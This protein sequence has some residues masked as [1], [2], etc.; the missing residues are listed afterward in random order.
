MKYLITLIALFIGANAMGQNLKLLTKS[1]QDVLDYQSNIGGVVF[2]KPFTKNGKRFLKYDLIYQGKDGE[3]Y[4]NYTF[5]KDSCTQ[6]MVSY[7]GSYEKY[8]KPLLSKKYQL[9][10]SMNWV[11]VAQRLQ[12]TVLDFPEKNFYSLV[13]QKTK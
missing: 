10:N 3:V 9:Y 6:I 1:Y 11:Q 13:Y 4:Y 7:N 5:N 8:R 2:P 12:I